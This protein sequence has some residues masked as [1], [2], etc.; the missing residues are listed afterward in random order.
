MR[1]GKS[2]IH[3]TFLIV[4]IVA[5]TGCTALKRCAYEGFNR[6]EWQ[7]PDRVIQALRLQPGDQV[8]DLGAGSGYFTFRLAEAVG[9]TGQVL[10]IDVDPGMLA[11]VEEQAQARGLPNIQTILADPDDPKLSTIGLALVFTCNTYHHLENRAAYFGRLKPYLRPGGRIA[12]IDFKPEGWLQAL[13]R[14]NTPSAVIRREMV[15]A[16]YTLERELTFLPKQSF[17]VFTAP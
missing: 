5:C 17:L 13:I 6:D 1:P 11:Y 9:P 2:P 14:H 10:A 3:R 8:V 7:Q 15:E 4:L 16:G 12:I